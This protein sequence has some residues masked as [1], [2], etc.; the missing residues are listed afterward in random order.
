LPQ[1]RQRDKLTPPA[2]ADLIDREVD[3]AESI[4]HTSILLAAAG[5]PSWVCT[6]HVPQLLNAG[7]CCRVSWVRVGEN[8]K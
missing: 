3:S 4:L 2:L 5:F 1:T 8:S 6:D 7:T